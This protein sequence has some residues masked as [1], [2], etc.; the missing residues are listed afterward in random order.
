MTLTGH[1]LTHPMTGNSA[2]SSMHEI[3]IYR[4]NSNIWHISIEG[5]VPGLYG[6]S[7]NRNDARTAAS[8]RE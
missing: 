6:E 3:P 8:L 1:G 5:Y 7:V 2:V 4:E